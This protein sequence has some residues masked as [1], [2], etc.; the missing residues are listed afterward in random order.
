MRLPYARLDWRSNSA[1]RITCNLAERMRKSNLRR[2]PQQAPVDLTK[3][4]QPQTAA[5]LDALLQSVLDKA[6]KGEM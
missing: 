2:V 1:K 6:F 4:L 3:R 5:E